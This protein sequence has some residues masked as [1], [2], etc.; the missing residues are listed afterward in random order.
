[1]DRRMNSEIEG[2]DRKKEG[3]IDREKD[4]EI[5]RYRKITIGHAAQARRSSL[6][7]PNASSSSAA[8]T[9]LP[10]AVP[11]YI[12][13]CILHMAYSI[14]HMACHIAY[15]T[16]NIAHQRVHITHSIAR[17]HITHTLHIKEYVLHIAYDLGG[18]LCRQ[19][20]LAQNR[21]LG[22]SKRD[23]SL[24]EALRYALRVRCQKRP[25]IHV[26]GAV[27]CPLVPSTTR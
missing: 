20:I 5:G 9:N 6:D 2:L 7:S 22:R 23:E 16:S 24:L 21:L 1:M 17:V 8:P 18:I 13:H 4:G 12:S 27:W 25:M 19:T 14:L 15:C 11:C 26:D 3:W 10:T